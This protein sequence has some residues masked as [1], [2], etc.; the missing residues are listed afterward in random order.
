[1]HVHMA[2]LQLLQLMDWDRSDMSFD[3]TRELPGLVLEFS[4]ASLSCQWMSSVTQ[5]DILID[6]RWSQI[7]RLQGSNGLTVWNL[8][9]PCSRAF[10]GTAG[11]TAVGPFLG[12]PGVSPSSSAARARTERGLLSQ[13]VVGAAH[14]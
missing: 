14:P 1:M 6:A 4:A 5:G 7:Q 9:E 3:L 10:P 8:V 11:W 13:H 2:C 12:F